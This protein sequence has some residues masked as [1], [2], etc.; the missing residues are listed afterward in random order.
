MTEEFVDIYDENNNLLNIS[1]TKN[2]AH[3]KGLWHRAVHI[4]IYT[5]KKELILQLRAK[6]KQIYPGLWDISAAGHVS[7]G[8]DSTVSALREIEEEIGLKVRKEDLNFL[9][10]KKI[11]GV[12]NDVRNN[13]FCYVYFLKYSGDISKLKLQ[14]EEVEEI[15]FISFDNFEKELK[16]NPEKYVPYAESWLE[17]I[18]EIKKRLNF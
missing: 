11:K 9:K 7:A 5:P 14:E 8:E 6:G 12:Y 4:W 3:K 17:T 2:E 16:T 15:R 13:E 10:I 1:K 18:G